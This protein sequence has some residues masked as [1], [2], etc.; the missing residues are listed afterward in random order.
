MMAQL[1]QK[2]LIFEGDTSKVYTSAVHTPGTVAFDS[3]GN[4]YIFMQGVSGITSTTNWVSFDEN[5]VTTLLAANAVG[6]VAIAMA[7]IDA[8]TKY[9]WFQIYGK[10]AI[11][12]SDAIP[13]DKQMYIDATAGRVDDAAVTGDLIIGAISRSTDSSTNI[14]T[15][16]LNYPFVSDTLG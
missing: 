11:G 13:T 15:F 12:G 7:Q 3:D 4:E 6:R 2:G 1:Q 5:F 14:A 10:N 8:T 9:G 16:E